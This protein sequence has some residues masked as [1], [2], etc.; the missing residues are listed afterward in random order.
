MKG[1]YKRFMQRQTTKA[2]TDSMS[3]YV[4]ILEQLTDASGDGR[5]YRDDPRPLNIRLKPNEVYAVRCSDDDRY[6]KTVMIKRNDL[7]GKFQTFISN[8]VPGDP[9]PDMPEIS[10]E[11][12]FKQMREMNAGMVV[13]QDL[14]AFPFR[15]HMGNAQQAPGNGLVSDLHKGLLRGDR[16]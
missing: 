5:S 12:V 15:G 4:Q 8:V 16:S 13:G 6:F 14:E 9:P 3:S 11:Q 7:T 1:Q 10:S 2:F